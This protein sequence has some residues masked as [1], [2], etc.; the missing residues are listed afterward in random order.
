MVIRRYQQ[1][2]SYE[3]LV[4]NMSP[5]DRLSSGRSGW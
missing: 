3:E 1:R 5:D 2:S 4:R